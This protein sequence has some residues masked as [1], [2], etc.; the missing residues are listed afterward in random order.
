MRTEDQIKAKLTQLQ[1]VQKQ[2]DTEEIRIQIEMLE[3]VLNQ[4]VGNTMP[5]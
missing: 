2:F 5:E 4:P 1:T 3:W